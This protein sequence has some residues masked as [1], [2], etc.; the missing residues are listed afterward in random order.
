MARLL[1]AFKFAQG[2][3]RTAYFFTFQAYTAKEMEEEHGSALAPMGLDTTGRGED[4]ENHFL[5]NVN[6][7]VVPKRSMKLLRRDAGHEVIHAML[8]KMYLRNSLKNC[9]NATY[10][11]Q[12]A[13]FGDDDE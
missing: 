2:R 8:Y 11:F 4:D 9:E 10:A 1:S 13:L 12:R 5:I 7:D 6:I 3:T